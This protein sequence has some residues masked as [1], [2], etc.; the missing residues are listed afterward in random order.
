MGSIIMALPCTATHAALTALSTLQLTDTGA[1]VE[2]IGCVHSRQ[3]QGPQIP[4]LV[5]AH[6]RSSPL[7]TQERAHA[8]W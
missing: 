3:A 2:H 4:C 1:S 6:S 5:A 8:R 7:K